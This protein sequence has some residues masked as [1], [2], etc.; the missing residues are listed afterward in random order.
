MRN[1]SNLL[2]AV[3]FPFQAGW[4][5]C[6]KAD[7]PAA[8]RILSVTYSGSGC[9]QDSNNGMTADANNLN[10]SFPSFNARFN[11][12][13]DNVNCQIH[14]SLGGGAPGWQLSLEQVNVKGTLWEADDAQVAFYT[15]VFWSQTASDTVRVHSSLIPQRDI[16]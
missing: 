4:G 11:S 7:P 8:P 12:Q 2:L 3:V 6:T 9:P 16:H 1:L 5:A 13:G 14:L 15:T 10:F